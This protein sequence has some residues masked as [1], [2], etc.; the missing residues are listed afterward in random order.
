MWIFTRWGGHLFWRFWKLFSNSSQ[1]VGLYCSCHADQASKDNFQKTCYKTFGT[2]GHPTQYMPPFLT[3]WVCCTI[4]APQ[5]HLVCF[6]S[7]FFMVSKSLHFIHMQNVG[8]KRS[9]FSLVRATK[10]DLSFLPSI[11]LNCQGRKSYRRT[12]RFGGLFSGNFMEREGTHSAMVKLWPRFLKIS[13][14]AFT[15]HWFSLFSVNR[16]L[17]NCTDMLKKLR[18]RLRDPAL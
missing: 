10:G 1:T 17:L 2:S 16:L 3:N 15:S 18:D 8:V 11:D 6:P 7:C 4:S 12:N 9:T 13:P 5:V 14:T